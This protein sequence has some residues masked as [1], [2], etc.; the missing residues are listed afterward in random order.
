V[1][2]LPLDYIFGLPFVDNKRLQRRPKKSGCGF[3]RNHA[4]NNAQVSQLRRRFTID[5]IL[6]AHF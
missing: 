3:R 2:F 4:C 1:A 6:W 5:G